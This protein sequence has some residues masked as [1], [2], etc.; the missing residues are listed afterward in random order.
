MIT[1]QSLAGLYREAHNKMRNLDG[2]QPQEAFEEFLKYLLFRQNN[3]TSGERVGLSRTLNFDGGF[4]MGDADAA[5]A[6]RRHFATYLKDFQGSAKDLWSDRKFRLSDTALLALHELFIGVEFSAVSFDVRSAALREFLGP[7]LRRGLGIYLTPDDVVRAI[8]EA[9][10]PEHGATVYDPACGSGTFLIEALQFWRD[11]HPRARTLR[12]QGSDINGRMLLLAELNLGHTKGVEFSRRTLDALAP[13]DGDAWPQPNSVDVI[14]TNP[15]FGV[16]VEPTAIDVQRFTTIGKRSPGGRLQSEV[17]FIEQCL[18]WLRPGGLLAIVVPRSVVTNESLAEARRAIDALSVLAGMLTLPPETFASTGTQTNTSVLFL[19]KRRERDLEDGDIEVPVVDVT[20]VGHDSTGRARVGS[21]LAQA[22]KDLRESMGTGRAVGLVR[23]LVVPRASSLSAVANASTRRTTTSTT[24]RLADIVDLAQTGRTP[25]R[26]AYTPDGVFTL[27]VGNLTG[28][29]IDWAPRDRN[30]VAPKFVSDALLLA[31]GDIVLTSS[32]HHPKYIAQ[33]VDIVHAIP[34]FAG[35]KATF[36]GEVLRLRVKP[37]CWSP[38][39]L[40][41]FL[42][43]PSTKA[44]IRDMVRGQTAH[45]RPKDLLELPVPD[46]AISPRLVELLKRE[47]EIARELNLI[48]A[49][50][51]EILGEEIPVAE[52]LQALAPT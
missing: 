9:V 3:E 24:R 49:G 25:A 11:A 51:R 34:A 43:S 35:G 13:G 50:Q 8:V 46:E 28:Q 45:L 15:P 47:A 52:E 29:G 39:E 5:K 6:I 32:A 10:A 44:T 31:E 26:A 20:N 37:G 27:K 21:Q 40:L 12:V 7:D 42:R 33:K 4:R 36:V 22:G 14:L 48:M 19:R 17:L 41:A 23:H 38:F 30:F 1:A 16:Y 18:R 2:L